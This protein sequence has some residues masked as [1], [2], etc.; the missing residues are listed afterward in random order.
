MVQ[1]PEASGGLIS[2]RTPGYTRISTNFVAEVNAHI[3]VYFNQ[4]S[5][6]STAYGYVLLEQWTRIAILAGSGLLYPHH[7]VTHVILQ[8]W[9]HT[10]DLTSLWHRSRVACC[11]FRT[12]ISKIKQTR[13]STTIRLWI[14]IIYTV[15]YNFLSEALS[16][17]FK[18]PLSTSIS[19]RTC[20]MITIDFPPC[21]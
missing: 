20:L 7:H 21:P 9:K 8:G 18:V 1:A 16:N 13:L 3:E 12:E 15:D 4:S 11:S 14:L 19:Y 10:P 2:G 17:L 5:S 6:M